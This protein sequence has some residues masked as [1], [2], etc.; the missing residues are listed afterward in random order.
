MPY[1]STS[2]TFRT[3]STLIF[4]AMDTTSGAL[5]RTLFLL[6][7]NQEVQAKLRAEIRDAYERSGT[8]RLGYDELVA[9]PYLDA[10]CRETLR[11]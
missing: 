1:R 8:D 2:L 5:A 9:L 10:V 3:R 7:Q 4:A 11:M 6:S